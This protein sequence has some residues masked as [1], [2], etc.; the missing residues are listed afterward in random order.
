MK[1]VIALLL[2]LMM[3]PIFTIAT[4]A[5]GTVPTMDEQEFKEV[6]L[7]QFTDTPATDYGADLIRAYRNVSVDQLDALRSYH[8]GLTTA[9]VAGV[10]SPNTSVISHAE[11]KIL[12]YGFIKLMT[13]PNAKNG[14]V[15]APNTAD[16]NIGTADIDRA[17]AT[18][19]TDVTI[20][21]TTAKPADIL[22]KLTFDASTD[23]N[24]YMTKNALGAF[25]I[26][27]Q[28]NLRAQAAANL[29]GFLSA[30]ATPGADAFVDAIVNPYL[31]QAVADALTTPAGA[32]L[33]VAKTAMIGNG[34]VTVTGGNVDVSSPF[35]QFI[36]ATINALKTNN[37]DVMAVVMNTI[38][39][40]VMDAKVEV[41]ADAA[42]TQKIATVEPN[43]VVA[44]LRE[45]D[46]VYLKV[47]SDTLASLAGEA[48]LPFVP[49]LS[50][51]LDVAVVDAADALQSIATV[52]RESGM[53][54]LTG[55]SDGS[56]ILKLY[57]NTNVAYDFNDA[58]RHNDKE[59]F[60]ELNF[61]VSAGG[62]RPVPTTKRVEAPVISYEVTPDNNA[63]VTLETA[64][65]GATIYYTTDGSTPTDK[66]QKYEGPFIVADGT[67][68][69]AIAV[70][71][72]YI[73]SYVTVE[74]IDIESDKIPT[75]TSEHIAY[76]HGRDTGNFDAEDYVTRGEVSA[77]FSRLIVK[78]M[79]FKDNSVSKFSDVDNEDW[80][81]AYVKYL[82]NVDIIKGY[83]DGT[84]KPNAPITRAELATVASRFFE[85]EIGTSNQFTDVAD[86]HWA[87]EYIDSAVVKG[88]LLGYEDGTFRPDQPIKR[89]E[90]VTI[91]NRMLNRVADKDY[92]EANYD[93]VL[94]YPDLDES[95]WAYYEI[96]EASNWH[97]HKIENNKEFWTDIFYQERFSAS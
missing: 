39:S 45:G 17:A 81:A 96:L 49:S 58:A 46:T 36:V 57:R 53:L 55:V 19:Y 73:D 13:F 1:R 9:V 50:P 8:D 22:N 62:G 25:V 21:G 95:H 60:M 88:W 33:G 4:Q 51:S 65:E 29:S 97:D 40:G 41:Y 79:V 3:L 59:L 31:Q 16:N 70:K 12:A 86:S 87:K 20:D 42:G 63:E 71:P 91:V 5:A 44:N 35:V 66:S 34:M 78:K 6:L 92:I 72:G 68:I 18:F 93:E 52:T 77:I 11:A 2:A 30:F 54:K 82:S 10:N 23:T 85:I 74:I 26:N 14:T 38:M 84:F 32:E 94:T 75:L 24:G 67:T 90:T 89:S 76:V 83:E 37:A 7:G 61:T 64:T 80:Y 28:K 69:K 43:N 27:L 47:I 56:A 48:A 15:A